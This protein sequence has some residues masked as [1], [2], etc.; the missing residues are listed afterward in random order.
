MDKKKAWHTTIK[1]ERLRRSWTQAKLAEMCG[2]SV[3]TVRRWEGGGTRL[4]GLYLRQKI[5]EAFGMSLEELGLAEEILEESVDAEE[6]VDEFY[7]SS[8]IPWKL[9]EVEARA[10]S[11]LRV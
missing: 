7:N 8:G 10:V 2:S 9:S 6:D 4:P 3:K 5:A 11:G 1:R